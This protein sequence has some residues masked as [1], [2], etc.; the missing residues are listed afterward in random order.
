MVFRLDR[1]LMA[2][3]DDLLD[4]GAGL[5]FQGQL[6]QILPTVL[7]EKPTSYNGLSLFSKKTNVNPGANTFEQRMYT[8]SGIAAWIE[9]YSQDLPRVGVNAKTETFHTKRMGDSYGWTLDELKAARMTG[10]PLETD[11]GVAARRAIEEKHNKTVWLGD[12]NVGLHGVLN[13]PY[14]PHI[15]LAQPITSGAATVA[16][17]I[18]AL[19]DFVDG[20]ESLTKQVARGTRLMMPTSAYQ[21]I[22]TTES[23]ADGVTILNWIKACRPE[24]TILKVPELDN[25]YHALGT[26]RFVCDA[27]GVFEWVVPG[28]EMFIQE[29]IERENLYFKVNC[30][31]KSGGVVTNWPLE[32]AI[33]ISP[34]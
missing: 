10:T 7:R 11:L 22:S 17:L 34:S 13:Y 16:A 20:I 1:A 24:L 18:R 2:K 5:W 29:D 32:A 30:H 3:L 21:Y 27:P 19:F 23:D 12:E 8:E 9:N 28:N 33:G 25:D 4:P 6:N 26:D 31:G 15:T 14:V